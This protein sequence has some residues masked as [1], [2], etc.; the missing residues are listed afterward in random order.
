MGEEPRVVHHTVR[1]C[2]VRIEASMAEYLGFV[3]PLI[4]LVSVVNEPNQ[5]SQ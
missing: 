4:S 1:Y 5:S 2:R 3:V